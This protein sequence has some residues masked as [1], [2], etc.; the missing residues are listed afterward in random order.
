M[1]MGGDCS[2]ECISNL[3]IVT[4]LCHEIKQAENQAMVTSKTGNVNVQ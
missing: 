3:F 1:A 2:S 4:R